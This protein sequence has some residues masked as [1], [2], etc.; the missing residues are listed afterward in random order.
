MAALKILIVEDELSELFKEAAELL[1]G[2]EHTVHTATTGSS[3]VRK[4]RALNPDIIIMDLRL[5]RM[6]GLT[7]IREIRNFNETV[8]IFALTAF[9]ENFRRQEALDAGAKGFISKPYE[10]KKM[11]KL[12][13]EVLDKE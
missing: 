6:D 1:C 13:R 7:A 10:L 12:V 11:L 8:I 3:G 4:A 5:P 9:N 2:G